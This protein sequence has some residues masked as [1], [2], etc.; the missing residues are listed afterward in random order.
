MFQNHYV[1]VSVLT[2]KEMSNIDLLLIKDMIAAIITANGVS[3][4][5]PIRT[6]VAP[7]L[8]TCQQK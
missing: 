2:D 7:S 6:A 3:M 8:Y 4:E 5:L 1:F